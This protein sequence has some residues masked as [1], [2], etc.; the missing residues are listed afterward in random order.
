MELFRNM[1][2]SD[3]ENV[4]SLNDAEVHQTSPMSLEQLDA[5]YRMSSYAKV[6]TLDGEVAAFL[7]ALRQDALYQNDNFQWFKARF[8]D[9]LYVDRIVV[10]ARFAGRGI[11]R[12]L[13][14]DMFSFARDAGIPVIACEYNIVPPNPAS[15]AFHDRFG[16]TE[17]GTQWLGGRTKKV[18][19]QVAETAAHFWR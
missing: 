10:G 18:S 2:Q 12:K 15:Q 19:L 7:L 11:G 14:G 8:S 9:F 3:F 17:R 6:A 16:F 4:L 13:Y 1:V 5:L